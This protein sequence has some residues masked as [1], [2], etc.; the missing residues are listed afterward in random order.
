MRTKLTVPFFA[1]VFTLAA[2]GGPK[3]GGGLR[4]D[5][6]QFSSEWLEV[7][8]GGLM[9]VPG[10]GPSL[11][12]N[13]KNT[14]RKTLWVEVEF[15]TPHA[16]SCTVDKVLEVSSGGMFVC[17]QTTLVADQDYPVLVRTYSDS[18]R[19]KLLES[20]QTHFRFDAKDVAKFESLVQSMQSAQKD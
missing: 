1:I 6:S 9:A 8:M 14:S 12:L 18:E 7:T 2:C 13:L 11:T 5:S 4:P 19:T 16:S 17:A 20:T 10:E 15:S 3:E